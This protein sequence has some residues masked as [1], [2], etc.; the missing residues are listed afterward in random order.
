MGNKQRVHMDTENGIIDRGDS[1][2]REGG[3]EVKN[4]KSPIGYNVH[5]WGDGYIKV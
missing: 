5:D 2:R 1:K 4:E 3:R